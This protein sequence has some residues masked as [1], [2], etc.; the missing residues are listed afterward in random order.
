VIQV[1]RA[2]I[3]R[4][5]ASQSGSDAPET[6]LADEAI[7]KQVLAMGRAADE[8]EQTGGGEITALGLQ[9]KRVALQAA[10]LAVLVKYDAEDEDDTMPALP[11]QGRVPTM[12][13]VSI[14]IETSVSEAVKRLGVDAIELDVLQETHRQLTEA[15][16]S[17]KRTRLENREEE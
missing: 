9:A 3:A 12:E 10:R 8:L 16:E 4:T 11:P 6:Q 1:F 15:L 13:D 17:L 7:A 5:N 14:T 2:A